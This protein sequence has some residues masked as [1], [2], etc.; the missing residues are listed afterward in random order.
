MHTSLPSKHNFRSYLLTL[1]LQARFQ[2]CSAG[3][4]L[5]V[6]RA[7]HCESSSDGLTPALPAPSAVRS[8]GFSLLVLR[9]PYCESSSDGLKPALPAPPAVRSAGFSL[10]VARTALRK[11]F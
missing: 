6:L 7:P 5:L 9:A 11:L 8:A 2:G 3:F 10:L 1:G 4:S